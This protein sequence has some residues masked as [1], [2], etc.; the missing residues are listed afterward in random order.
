MTQDWQD[1]SSLPAPVRE[2]LTKLC[3]QLQDALGERLIAVVLHGGLARGE[4]APH[5]SDV[6]VM[7]VL[8][9]A[10][11]EELDM[12][13][14]PVRQ[15]M[16][17]FRLSV[18][19]VTEEGLRRSTDVFPIKFLDMQKHHRVL[20]GKDPLADLQIDSAHLR[21]RCEQEIKNL[22]YKLR[23]FYLQ[24]GSRPE[25]IESTLGTA[26]SSFLRSLS[27]LL[28]LRTGRSPTAKDEIAEAAIRELGLDGKPLQEA[29]RLKS[30]TYI[31]DVTELKRL[32]GE[33][34]ATVQ[35][36]AEIVDRE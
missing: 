11:V 10:T 30:R 22:L 2:G 35:K 1:D 27:V 12:A 20:W 14:S 33:F 17:D 15:G 18:M 25:L 31:P 3:G 8:R 26:V 29:L 9:E 23:H 6:N 19:V 7:L 28:I 24:R 36:V 13:M 34:M 16:R 32:Y 21:L 5:S 4:Y